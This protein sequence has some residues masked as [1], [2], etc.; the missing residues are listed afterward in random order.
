[1]LALVEFDGESFCIHRFQGGVRVPSN[2]HLDSKQ[3]LN[4]D[5][6]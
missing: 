6:L 2:S 1:M 3:G 5:N 4:Q